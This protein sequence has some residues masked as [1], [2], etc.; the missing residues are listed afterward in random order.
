MIST[1]LDW[2]HHKVAFSIVLI[3]YLW[4]GKASKLFDNAF[5]ELGF[6]TKRSNEDEEMLT[7]IGQIGEQSYSPSTS[8][9]R[10]MYSE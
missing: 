4:T 5:L 6:K 1:I 9:R 8:L 10:K 7:T 2:D 3:V